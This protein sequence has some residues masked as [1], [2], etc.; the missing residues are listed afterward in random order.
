[1]TEWLLRRFAG[2]HKSTDENNMR[3]RYGMFSG[4]VG[5]V[6][7]LFLFVLKLGAGLAMHSI[8]VVSDAFNNLSDGCSCVITLVGYRLAGKPADKEHP[9]GHGRVE[10]LVA[11]IVSVIIILSGFELLQSSF[12]KLF[13]GNKIIFQP[14]LF[15][16]LVLSIAVKLWMRSFYT[17]VG[18]QIGSAALLASA[19]DAANDV[20]AT[21]LTLVAM[22]LNVYTERFPFDAAAGMVVSAMIIYSGIQI[23]KDILD[24]LLGTPADRELAS[25]IELMIL[26]HKEIRG[27][28]DLMIHDYGPGTQIASAHIEIDQNMPFYNAHRIAD[29]IENEVSSKMNVSITLHMD[30]VETDNPLTAEY[31]QEASGVL[32]SIDPNLRIQDFHAGYGENY[33]NLIFEV[34]VPYDCT[35]D[36]DVLNRALNDAFYSRNVTVSPIYKHSFVSEET[37]L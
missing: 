31:L 28:H 19:Q 15:V 9:F 32:H 25:Q 6:C 8:A 33:T 4:A 16:F 17:T 12:E 10:Y 30:P 34:V 13:A 27:M 35:A 3:T 36:T 20:L 1:M 21:S 23:G 18:K 22:A 5:L 11:L 37:K 14:V 29:E 24:R 2:A 7:N 26:S